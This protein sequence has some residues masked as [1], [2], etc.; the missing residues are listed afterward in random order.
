MTIIITIFKSFLSS[1]Q[2]GK[3]VQAQKTNIL[4]TKARPQQQRKKKQAKSTNYLVVKHASGS[5]RSETKKNKRKQIKEQHQDKEITRISVQEAT[6]S[7]PHPRN[8]TRRLP[9]SVG[10]FVKRLNMSSSDLI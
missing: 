1:F 7:A 3:A 2:I 8:P 6:A 10:G 4:A 9:D 5:P